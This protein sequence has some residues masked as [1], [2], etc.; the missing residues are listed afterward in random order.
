[1]PVNE[2]TL[3]QAIITE[4]QMKGY[5]YVYGPDISRDYHEVILEDCFRS[6]MLNINS[7][8]TQ[9]I[10]T[11]AYKMIKNLGLLRLEDLNA[12]FHKYLIEGVPIPYKKAE[13]DTMINPRP[14]FNI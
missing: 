14:M 13:I 12:A 7:G 1:M 10:I 4:L 9:E 2:N 11:E 8:I 3:E 5:E 6:S